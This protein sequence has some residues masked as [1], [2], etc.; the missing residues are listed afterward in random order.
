ML[1]ENRMMTSLMM[2][3]SYITSPPS[4]PLN[5]FLPPPLFPDP[6]HL[7]ASSIWDEDILDRHSRCSLYSPP[8]FPAYI[9]I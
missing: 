6:L 2:M 7:G 4:T 8:D 3:T 1:E 5:P 9:L